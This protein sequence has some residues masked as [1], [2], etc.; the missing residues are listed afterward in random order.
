LD[1]PQKL[2]VKERPEAVQRT[3]GFMYALHREQRTGPPSVTSTICAA[4]HNA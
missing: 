1:R 3:Y 4:G 2:H